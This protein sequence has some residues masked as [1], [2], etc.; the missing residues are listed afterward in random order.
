VAAAAMAFLLGLAHR[1]RSKDR[2]TREGLW[3]TRLDYQGYGLVGRTLG[4][5]GFGNIGREIA[6]LAR[7]F[8]LK[9]I[10]HDPYLSPGSG[11]SEVELVGLEELLQ[12]SDFVCLACP[13][14]EQT[15]HLIDA[16]ALAL[17]KPSA[18]LINVARGPVVDEP[19]LVEVL[20]RRAI[21]GAA[22]DVFEEEPPALDNPLFSLDNVILAPHSAAWTDEVFRDNGREAFGSIVA[23]LDHRRPDHIVNRDVLEHPRVAEWLRQPELTPG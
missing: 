15:R 1:I 4:I 19:A 16:A 8:D 10:V 3:H 20:R 22:L 12:R 21:M 9:V 5:V 6:R 2:I 13:L 17:M 18:F 23:L 14:T 7:P 11:E